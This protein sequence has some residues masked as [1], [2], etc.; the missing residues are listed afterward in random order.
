MV[1]PRVGTS[2]LQYYPARQDVPTNPLALIIMETTNPFLTKFE[3]IS[4]GEN[5]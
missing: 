4:T 1:L 2:M 3:A 5:L